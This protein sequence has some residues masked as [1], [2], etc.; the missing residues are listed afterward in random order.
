MG[1]LGEGHFGGKDRV[2]ELM[3]DFVLFDGGIKKRL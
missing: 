1:G 2:I 3:H